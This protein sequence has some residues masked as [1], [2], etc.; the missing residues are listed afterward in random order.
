MT[1]ALATTTAPSFTSSRGGG[2]LFSVLQNH[3][4]TP[5]AARLERHKT[6]VVVVRCRLNRRRIVV[7]TACERDEPTGR[8][9]TTKGRSAVRRIREVDFSGNENEYVNPIEEEDTLP[10]CWTEEEEEKRAFIKRTDFA[11]TTTTTTRENDD[12]DDAVRRRTSRAQFIKRIFLPD[13][14]RTRFLR[15]ICLG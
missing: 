12:D 8:R 14:S 11:T 1:P 6:T 4:R 7:V 15:I 13:G 3:N 2:P 10:R 9:G 5:I